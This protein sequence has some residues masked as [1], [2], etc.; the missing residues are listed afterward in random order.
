MVPAAFDFKAKKIEKYNANVPLITET[1]TAC[2]QLH[3]IA[4]SIPSVADAAGGMTRDHTEGAE[5]E[6]D[7]S[8]EA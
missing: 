4:D 7:L 3:K 6:A 5:E 1:G 8:V 2:F